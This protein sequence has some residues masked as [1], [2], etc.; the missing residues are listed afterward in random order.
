LVHAVEVDSQQ[1]ENKVYS[2]VG[3]VHGEV[4][5]VPLSDSSWL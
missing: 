2:K 3:E 4:A 1:R 5:N